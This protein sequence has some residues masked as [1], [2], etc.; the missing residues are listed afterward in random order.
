MYAMPG[1]GPVDEAGHSQRLA[2]CGR[3]L[4]A[5]AAAECEIGI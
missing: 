1:I 2:V 3:L 4:N 5:G